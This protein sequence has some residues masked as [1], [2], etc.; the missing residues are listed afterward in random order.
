MTLESE[1][2]AICESSHGEHVRLRRIR[3]PVTLKGLCA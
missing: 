1:D 3:G 2:V